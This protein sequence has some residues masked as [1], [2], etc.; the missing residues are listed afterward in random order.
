MHRILV[1]LDV[2]HGGR[3]RRATPPPSPA[4]SA[5]SRSAGTLFTAEGPA[6]VRRFVE[7]GHRVFLDLKF[8]DIPHQVSGA[9][10]SAAA[11]G[12]WMLTI[13]ASGGARHDGP[14]PTPPA[15]PRRSWARRAPLVIGVTVLTSLD[16]AALAEVGVA[17]PLVEQVE[18]LAVLARESGHRRR[19]GV[20]AG[21]GAAARAVRAGL[22]DRHAGHPAAPPPGAAHGRSGAHADGVRGD[23]RPAPVYL[24]VGRP[25]PR[26]R[27]SARRRRSPSP[28]NRADSEQLR[29]RLPTL[30]RSRP[31]PSK[32]LQ[33]VKRPAA[34]RGAGRSVGLAHRAARPRY[35]AVI[36]KWPRRFCE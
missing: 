16:E 9:V 8:H 4:P 12:A 10:R 26:R 5:A 22:P 36:R 32:A 27:R 31:E 35:F 15:T 18:R 2:D 29:E 20:A 23:R 24:V 11:L 34:R 13:H 1:A 7:Q 19:R 21:G 33:K 17:R 30:L 25:D 6:L 3:R 14:P 28:P